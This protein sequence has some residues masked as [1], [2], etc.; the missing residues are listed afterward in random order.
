MKVSMSERVDRV[1]IAPTFEVPSYRTFGWNQI[2]SVTRVLIS[3]VVLST[4]SGC[5]SFRG[6]QQRVTSV[7]FTRDTMVC[8]SKADLDNPNPGLSKGAYRD[9]IIGLCLKA[10]QAK[11]DEFKNAM[12]MESGATTLGLDVLSQSLSS[13]GAVLNGEQ[14]V[15][16]LAAGSAFS[17]SLSATINKDLFYKQAL[18][19][20]I[21]SMDARRNTIITGILQNQ[22]LDREARTYTLDRAGYDLDVLQQAGSLASAIQELT[23][24]AVQNKVKTDEDVKDAA[25]GFN[26]G[27]F[28]AP[29]PA[30]GVRIDAA[31]ATIQGLQ[32]N[33]RV[34]AL[35]AILVDLKPVA[36]ELKIPAPASE[37]AQPLGNAIRKMLFAFSGDNMPVDRQEP[38]LTAIEAAIQ[39]N[40]D[41]P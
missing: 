8:P 6:T 18:P 10:I 41:L 22:N 24:N 5:A 36:T 28:Q 2:P 16:R 26:V 11:Y 29:P 31:F 34:N 19:A 12:W 33:N 14:T 30:I 20:L 25:V 38:I 23:N 32:N 1:H 9:R 27:V 40:K 15:R 3:F 4:L 39:M 13:L 17:Q 7:D 21:A 37:T 35:K